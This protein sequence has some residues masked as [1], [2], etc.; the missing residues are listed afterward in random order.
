MAKIRIE[1]EKK[2]FKGWKYIFMIL[3][4]AI[5]ISLSLNSETSMLKEWIFLNTIRVDEPVY[6]DSPSYGM[7]APPILEAKI[8]E[9]PEQRFYIDNETREILERVVEA[10][11]TG[12]SYSYKGT[13]L[14]YDQLL[15]AKIRV[16]QVFMNRVDAYREFSKIDT[17]K[18]SLLYPYAT[19][20]I[21]DGRYY[22]VS[23]TDIT[24]EAVDLALLN[25]TP[26]YTDGAL[27]F[28]SGTTS[29]P[30]GDLLFVDDVGHAFFK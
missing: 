13:K 11:V 1:L 20:T 27:Y 9:K 6:I 18:E 19:S 2:R 14:T 30:Y 5:M 26:D 12:S 4:I 22:K 24:K 25:E 15:H 10:E 8:L 17:L 21:S 23:V 7:S 3:N 29:S 28:A 16:A